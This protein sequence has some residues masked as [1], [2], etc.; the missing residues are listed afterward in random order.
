M[1]RRETESE[2]TRTGFENG[3]RR[4]GTVRGFSAG[5]FLEGECCDEAM[6][7]WNRRLTVCSAPGYPLREEPVRLN[8]AQRWRF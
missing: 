3:T 5:A 1:G 6:R 2:S 4:G 8:V 7:G